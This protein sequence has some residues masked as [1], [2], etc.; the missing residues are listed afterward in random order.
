VSFRL[1]MRSIFRLAA[2]AALLALAPAGY[3]QQ[4]VRGRLL[5]KF[6]SNVSEPQGRAVAQGLGAQS[7]GSIPGTGV[8]ILQLPA[9]AN[10]NAFANAFR[11]RG[12][13]EFAELDVILPPSD[14]IPNDPEYAAQWHLP[15]VDAPA[16]WST[17]T[18]VSGVIIAIVDTGVDPTHPDLASKLVAG[19][20]T[21]D[22]T[23]NT[24]DVYGHGTK[25]AGTA[26][27][28]TNNAAGVAG[29]CWNCWIMPIRAAG[30]NGSATYSS[31][32]AGITWAADH[33]ARVANVSYMASTSSTV[34]SAA[35]YMRSRG[36]VVTI[37]AGNY[38]ALEPSPDN[39]YVLTVSATDPND[40]LY[41]WSNTGNNVDVAAPGCVYTTAM[42]GGY[43]S[44]C[45]TSFSAPIVAGVAALVM[46]QNPG[47]SGADV[48]ARIQQTADDRGA[49]GWDT[50]YGYGR[51]N[52]A[53][54]V[55]PNGASAPDT[56]A[57]TVS[58]TSPGAG[59]TVSGTVTVQAAASD[60]VGVTAVSFYVDGVLLGTDTS[61]PFS[62][63]W[64]T[65][66]SGNG[67]HTV[68]AQARDAAGNNASQSISVNVNNTTAPS[69]STGDTTA[70][71]VIITSPGA[72][73]RVSGNVSVLVNTSDNVGVVRVELYVDG[74]LTDAS[75][76]AP[77]T[78]TW[79]TNPRKVAPGA[80]SLQVR[81][82]DAAGNAGL[83]QIVTVYK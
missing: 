34:T 14:V 20:S 35:S 6:R 62:Y 9:N 59:S 4:F 36:G 29:V 28:I 68:T 82:Y 60:N 25:V 21:Y 37:S 58:V 55:N 48:M 57:P 44:S 83:S 26:A 19:W 75:T 81:A 1:S 17:T 54:A 73:A 13:V 18:G 33:G 64:N 69:P 23:S 71:A 65:G 31:L 11:Q 49:S 39:P 5:V 2:L 7:S 32:A 52:A 79:N 43:T 3:A 67:G 30:S 77:F 22:N 80:H 16:A 76:S 42:G 47:L 24:S 46:S 45:G 66:S 74:A 38:G 53:R 50:V 56:S 61:A 70:P 8:Q 72:G 10:E 51:V 63:S 27:A 78:T 40:V 15:R 41:S 12:E